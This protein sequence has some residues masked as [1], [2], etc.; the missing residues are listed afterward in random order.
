MQFPFD[1]SN[2]PGHAMNLAGGS[3]ASWMKRVLWA[4]GL[5]SISWGIAVT[6]WPS[7]VY[8]W[9]GLDSM[10][11]PEIW[12][13]V[14]MLTGLYGLAYLVSASNPLRHWPV[15]FIG[16]LTKLLGPIGF[17]HCVFLKQLP[18]RFGWTIV[19][20]DIVWWFPFCLILLRAYRDHVE[21]CRT[22][23]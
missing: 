1:R 18:W 13:Y 20:N 22:N 10:S 4:A 15:V 2:R 21:A 12:Q 23:S 5:Y 9:L 19:A 14:G 6:V 7:R 8:S 17:I 3:D 11:H 16:V